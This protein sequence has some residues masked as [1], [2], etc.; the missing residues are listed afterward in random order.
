MKAETRHLVRQR[1]EDRCEYCLFPAWTLDLP[2]HVEH[3]I[4]SVH[5]VDDSL[6]N[7]AW[8]C[9]RCNLKKGT[10]LAT[11]DPLTGDLIE[12]FNPRAMNWN[13][14][15]IVEEG[16]IQGTTKCGRGTVRLLDMNAEYRVLLRKQLMLQG[17]W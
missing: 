16:L 15:F 11:I 13:D 17:E 2:F 10:N 5:A 14:H 8:A 6:A 4:A 1:A 12:I 9:A 7:L 3:V